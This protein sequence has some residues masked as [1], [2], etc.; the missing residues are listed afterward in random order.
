MGVG[1]LQII[2]HSGANPGYNELT[3]TYGWLP[4]TK[5]HIISPCQHPHSSIWILSNHSDLFTIAQKCQ[6]FSWQKCQAFSC[7]LLPQSLCTCCFP[8][9]EGSSA[10]W[11]CSLPLCPL[12]YSN[13]MVSL[14]PSQLFQAHSICRP[15][16]FFLLTLILVTQY[17]FVH[18]LSKIEV[19]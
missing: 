18:D 3:E 15:G 8:L 11:P 12:I 13:V 1:V 9:L 17:T 2:H 6:A 4:N 10:R 5:T 14:R 19:L 16:L 7:I